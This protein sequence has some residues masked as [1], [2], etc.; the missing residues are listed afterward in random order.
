MKN[1]T[2]FKLNACCIS[3][4]ILTMCLR[5]FAPTSHVCDLIISAQLEII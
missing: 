2:S 5:A 1:K 4:L 3:K